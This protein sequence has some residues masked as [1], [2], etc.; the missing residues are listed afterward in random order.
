MATRAHAREALHDLESLLHDTPAAMGRLTR[1]RQPK[2]TNRNWSARCMSRL[3]QRRGLMLRLKRTSAIRLSATKW[4]PLLLGLS[5]TF[6]CYSVRG[7]QGGGQVEVAGDKGTA[8]LRAIKPEDIALPPGY[9]IEAA[10][11][12]LNMP[13]GVT[14]GPN[15]QLY[16][17]EGGYAY[18]ETFDVPRVLALGP[19]GSRKTIASGQNPPWNGVVFHEGSLFVSEGGAKQSGRILKISPGGEVSSLVEGLP[20]G[21]DHHTNGPT[22]GPDG[23][24]YF[25]QGTVTNAGVVGLDNQDYG[26]LSRSPQLHDIPCQDVTLRGVNYTTDNPLRTDG[27]KAETGAFVEFGTKT[28]PGQVI[29]GAVPCSGA[30]LRVASQ[31]GT[32]E[33]VAWGFR[34]PF[35]IAFAGDGRLFV[36]DNMYDERGSRP[37]FGV[38]D[39]LWQVKQGSWYGWPDYAGSRALSMK[40][41]ASPGKDP[42]ASV[43]AE[44]PGVPPHPTAELGV[45]SSS[46]GF[47]FARNAAFGY[48]G[49]AFVSQFGDMAPAAGKVL[50]PVGF[51]VVRVDPTSGVIH[52][53]A[54]NRKQAGPA[55]AQE[56]G[57]LERPIAARFDPSGK[58]LYVVDYGVLSL[59][60]HG[61]S[62]RK[63]SGVLWRISHAE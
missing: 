45:H 44:P 55:S 22:I 6:G 34:N 27:A 63:N 38:G 18:G 9:R 59:G 12:G 31:G 52:D 47:D 4:A 15:G 50:T 49:E 2:A 5:V 1:A 42:I 30:V 35:G 32:P 61:P 39:F 14:F 10:V 57:G 7:S 54:T 20:T 11:T 43:L 51:K 16:V 3:P 24:L 23:K 62:V 25:T 26:W 41:F 60:E 13:T 46:T 33:L 40:R 36:T 53:F 17:V 29:K 21:G 8:L 19:D 48:V 56:G 58:A 28:Q 37:V